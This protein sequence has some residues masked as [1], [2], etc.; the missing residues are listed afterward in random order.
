MVSRGK[1]NN[2]VS[3]TTGFCYLTSL[4]LE[5]IQTQKSFCFCCLRSNPARPSQL[6]L[7]CQCRQAQYYRLLQKEWY[8]PADGELLSTQR[9]LDCPGKSPSSVYAAHAVHAEL[10]PA[11]IDFAHCMGENMC[12]QDKAT[13]SFLHCSV[14]AT[15][16]GRWCTSTAKAVQRHYYYIS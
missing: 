13:A 12:H 3:R 15:W 5:G 6:A 14:K 9:V 11:Y 16:N 10:W 2:L 4:A 1:T 7:Y 8:W